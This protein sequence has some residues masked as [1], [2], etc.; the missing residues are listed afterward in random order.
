MCSSHLNAR[1]KTLEFVAA[2]VPAKF[3][4]TVR[5]VASVDARAHRICLQAFKRT[6]VFS[7]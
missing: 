4:F 1:L 7:A 5:V 3:R 2:N 6:G